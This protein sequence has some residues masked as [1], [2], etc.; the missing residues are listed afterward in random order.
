MWPNG[1]KLRAASGLL[2]EKWSMLNVHLLSY[3]ACGKFGEHERSVLVA[4]GEAECFSS[5]SAL[6]ASEVHL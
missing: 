2:F 6:S 1:Q 3:D 5:L 4:R